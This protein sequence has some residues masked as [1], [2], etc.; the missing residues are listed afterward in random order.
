MTMHR[1]R[2]LLDRSAG[3]RDRSPYVAGRRAAMGPQMGP[4]DPVI[5]GQSNAPQNPGFGEIIGR[6]TVCARA[7]GR[8][9]RYR[10]P[11]RR[12]AHPAGGTHGYEALAL[13][14]S[15]AWGAA[16]H[17]ARRIPV[18]RYRRGARARPCPP[19][20]DQA[21]HRPEKERQAVYRA[22]KRPPTSIVDHPT[23]E[24]N[25]TRPRTAD[26]D[27]SCCRGPRAG[28]PKARPWR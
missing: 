13:S 12:S 5:R 6:T 28:D 21:W 4:Q 24:Q 27:G 14:V 19:T 9:I 22:N 17:C 7:D 18:D 20:R 3:R 23:A 15:M 1:L 25:I 11:C 8:E 16:P 26:L 10:G 2:P